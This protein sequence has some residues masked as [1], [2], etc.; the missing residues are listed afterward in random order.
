MAKAKTRNV[1]RTILAILYLVVGAVTA[2]Q[3]FGL[4]LP[5]LLATAMGVIMCIAGFIALF[6]G[7][8]KL[9]RVFGVIIFVVAVVTLVLALLNKTGLSGLIW[10]II[11]AILAWAFIALI[12]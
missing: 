4:T 7:N 5:A 9:C 11:S 12:K 6:G 2:R 8:Y 1:L 10:P 3:N